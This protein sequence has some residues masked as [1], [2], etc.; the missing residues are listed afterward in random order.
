MGAAQTSNTPSQQ[1]PNDRI[2]G[3]LAC[4]CPVL[5][6]RE[7]EDGLILGSPPVME[8]NEHYLQCEPKA[9]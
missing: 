8:G 5:V 9:A 3:A 6:L 2:Q 7:G 4:P 1:P